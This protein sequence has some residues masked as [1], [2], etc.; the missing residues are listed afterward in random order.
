MENYPRFQNEVRVPIARIGCR[1]F[2]TGLFNMAR[3]RA[4]G[5]GAHRLEKD[6]SAAPAQKKR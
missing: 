3:L 6:G 5:H 2:S 4:S 1:E